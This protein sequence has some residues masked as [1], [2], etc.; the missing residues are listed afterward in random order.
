MVEADAHAYKMTAEYE[1]YKQLYS[2][3]D[4]ADVE[5]VKSISSKTSV[6]LHNGQLPLFVSS[7]KN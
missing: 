4:Y 2:L 7:N 6:I 5:K 3:K 1:G